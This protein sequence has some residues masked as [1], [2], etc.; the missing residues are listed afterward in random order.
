MARG[1]GRPPRMMTPQ[2]LDQAETMAGL[3]LRDDQIAQVLGMAE[4]TMTRHAR[5]RL[6]RGRAKALAAVAQTCYRLATSG[7]CPAATF[8]YLKTQGRWQ[9]VDRSVHVDANSTA[10][11]VRVV[12]PP[13]PSPKPG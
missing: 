8:F 2:E 11:T 1:P 3:G 10:G 9:E 5:D 4:R 12:I 13:D 7:R 6:H